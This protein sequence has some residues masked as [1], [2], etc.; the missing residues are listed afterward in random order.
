MTGSTYKRRPGDWAFQVYAGRSEEGKQIRI[1]KSGFP[2]KRA[3][4][5][6][7]LTAIQELQD[8]AALVNGKP[9]TLGQVLAV[10]LQDTEKRCAGTTIARYKAIVKHLA[11]EILKAPLDAIN[12][13][14]LENEFT[15]LREAGGQSRLTKQPRPLSGKTVKLVARFVSAAL[16][17]M[18]RLGQLRTNPARACHLPAV[19]R[20]EALVIDAAQLEQLLSTADGHHLQPL[21]LLAAATGLRRGELL[22]LQWEDVDLVLSMLSVNKSL[23]QTP[24]GLR[25][26]STK[27]EKPRMVKLPRLAVETLEQ[28]RRRQAK[29]SQEFGPGY[30]YDLNLIFANFAG[31]YR[32]PDTVTSEAC[33]LAQKAGLPGIGLHSLRHSHGSQLIS[34]GV[35]LPAVSKRLGHSSPRIT[36]EVYAHALPKDEEAAAEIWEKA[37]RATLQGSL[38]KAAKKRSAA[39][40]STNK[41]K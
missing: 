23:E 4:D 7:K 30:R 10:Y 11:P 5:T 35:P 28:H 39:K 18:V 15:R 25:I 1:T 20:D 40:C 26:K 16:N 14:V 19:E 37:M 27:S 2:T 8:R 38:K 17:N 6:A 32:R 3:A 13:L 31:E 21:I 24:A 41:A 9:Q 34:S 22:A 12:T 29:L 36:A 33:R